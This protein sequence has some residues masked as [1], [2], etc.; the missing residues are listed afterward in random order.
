MKE[1]KRLEERV[2]T[3]ERRLS[4]LEMFTVP[5]GPLKPE[6]PGDGRGWDLARDIL[7]RFNHG[8]V[9]SDLR[10]TGIHEDKMRI[11]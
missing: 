4:D 6:R 7:E 1:I 8:R 5:M 10:T 11:T 3:L 9:A 2:K